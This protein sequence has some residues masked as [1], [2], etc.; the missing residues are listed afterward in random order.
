M[1]VSPSMPPIKKPRQD[2]VNQSL[3]RTLV[4]LSNT[5]A[6]RPVRR[7]FQS[8]ATKTAAAVVKRATAS[9]AKSSTTT[10]TTVNSAA[11]PKATNGNH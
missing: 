9:I 1:Q 10:K 4:T 5:P 2:G 11:V 7:T 8:A 3:Q 6:A